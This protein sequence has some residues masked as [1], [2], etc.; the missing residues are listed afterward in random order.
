MWHLKCVSLGQSFD[1]LKSN[2][3]NSPHLVQVLSFPRLVKEGS[4]GGGCWSGMNIWLLMRQS[5]KK[6]LTIWVWICGHKENLTIASPSNYYLKEFQSQVF[7]VKHRALG[8]CTGWE[9]K[10]ADRL[11]KE[12]PKRISWRAEHYLVQ[13]YHTW[14]LIIQQIEWEMLLKEKD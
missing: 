10:T 8:K 14:T 11:D 4:S 13:H 1:R 9:P 12:L 5:S 3:L 6:I 2:C 7:S